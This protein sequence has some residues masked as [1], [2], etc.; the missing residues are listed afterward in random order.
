MIWLHLPGGFQDKL[1]LFIGPWLSPRRG[2]SEATSRASCCPSAALQRGFGSE[3]LV[4]V[5]TGRDE[6]N[7][8]NEAKA[9]LRNH[10]LLAREHLAPNWRDRMDIQAG[11]GWHVTE[12][13][14]FAQA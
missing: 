9:I 12:V 13:Q 8:E 1:S 14:R 10:Y 3:A 11:T 6:N 5:R 2:A 4:L 7:C